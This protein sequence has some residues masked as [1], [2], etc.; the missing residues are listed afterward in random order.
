LRVAV[1]VVKWAATTLFV[2]TLAAWTWTWWRTAEWKSRAGYPAVGAQL[3]QR[4]LTLVYIGVDPADPTGKTR[5]G[6]DRADDHASAAGCRWWQP[7]WTNGLTSRQPFWIVDLPL[8]VPLGVFRIG[9]GRF[10]VC[11]LEAAAGGAMSRVRI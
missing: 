8:L 10:V 6:H 7:R 11:G 1:R 2:L 4:V 3:N 9:G 5:G